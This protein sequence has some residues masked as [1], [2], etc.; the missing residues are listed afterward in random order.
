MCINEQLPIWAGNSF[1][2]VF[3]TLATEFLIS[4]LNGKFLTSTLTTCRLCSSSLIQDTCWRKRM[5]SMVAQTRRSRNLNVQPS[6]VWNSWLIPVISLYHRVTIF[7]RVRLGHSMDQWCQIPC[8]FQPDPSSVE[9]LDSIA[10]IS[11]RC[12]G[13]IHGHSWMND[14]TPEI[15]K[16]NTCDRSKRSPFECSNEVFKSWMDFNTESLLKQ[17]TGYLQLHDIWHQTLT[18]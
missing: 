11:L 4:L 14:V 18:V 15:H 9:V 1:F 12:N 3:P 8:F 17:G 2:T 13:M 5:P 10:W 6:N 7:M 16:K